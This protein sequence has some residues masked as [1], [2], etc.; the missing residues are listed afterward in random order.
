MSY[1]PLCGAYQTLSSQRREEYSMLISIPKGRPFPQE[2]E[3]SQT[4][5]KGS[6]YNRTRKTHPEP[7]Q[8]EETLL[9]WMAGILTEIGI[10]PKELRLNRST[11]SR[12]SLLPTF[13]QW[14]TFENLIKSRF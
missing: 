6:R 9:N 11:S 1:G 14:A 12:P 7:Q 13:G 10:S 3:S 5:H 4:H 8:R 2:T